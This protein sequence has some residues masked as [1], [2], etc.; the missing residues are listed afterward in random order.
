MNKKD[1]GAALEVA[2]FIVQAVGGQARAN[3]SDAPRSR[4]DFDVIF[5]SV[6]KSLT[7]YMYVEK[8]EKTPKSLSQRLAEKRLKKKLRHLKLQPLRR[9]TFRTS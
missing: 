4:K 9:T 7:S 8:V 2:D 6:E 1:G 5:K 3:M